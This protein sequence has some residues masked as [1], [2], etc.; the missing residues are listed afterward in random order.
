MEKDFHHDRPADSFMAQALLVP[1]QGKDFSRRE[2]ILP[3]SANGGSF[4]EQ[5]HASV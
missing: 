1:A 5:V 4:R 3:A 2:Q